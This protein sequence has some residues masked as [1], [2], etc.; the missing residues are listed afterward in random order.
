MYIVHCINE[1]EKVKE[2]NN[3]NLSWVITSDYG[4]LFM[5][6]YTSIKQSTEV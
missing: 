3:A 5:K 4:R 6:Q 1:Y 2:E